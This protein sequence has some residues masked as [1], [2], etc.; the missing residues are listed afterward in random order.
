MDRADH[1]A[2]RNGEVSDFLLSGLSS[3]V[4]LGSDCEVFFVPFAEKNKVGVAL[5]KS[6][7]KLLGKILV[8]KPVKK[9]VKKPEK[10]LG[11]LRVKPPLQLEL[12]VDWEVPPRLLV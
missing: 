7:V 8:K 6:P 3:G 11:K 5:V 10:L 2:D 12:E 1:L 4:V 9:T